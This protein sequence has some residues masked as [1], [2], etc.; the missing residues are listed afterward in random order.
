[1]QRG[2]LPL[3]AALEA[4]VREAG[5]MEVV[6]DAFL[7]RAAELSGV[8]V[9]VLRRMNEDGTLDRFMSERFWYLSLV[10]LGAVLDGISSGEVSGEVAG[11]LALDSA[12]VAQKLA[13]RD[14]QKR[15]IV[16]ADA[17]EHAALE[18]EACEVPATERERS[19]SWEHAALAAESHAEPIE[20][21]EVGDGD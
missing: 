19:G 6:G 4:A 5:P 15:Y 8:G 7:R 9:D 3:D 18:A 11:R 16:T 2:V 21:E 1:M 10:A 12:K 14:I 13:G 20:S 17:W